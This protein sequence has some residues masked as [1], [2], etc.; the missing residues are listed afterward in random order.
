MTKMHPSE[1]DLLHAAVEFL[2]GQMDEDKLREAARLSQCP[3]GARLRFLFAQSDRDGESF[4]KRR[5]GY[6]IKAHLPVP[7]HDLGFVNFDVER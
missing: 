2:S 6:W 5:L 4:L 3:A 7:Q 1:A